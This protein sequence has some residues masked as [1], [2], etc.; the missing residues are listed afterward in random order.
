MKI[1]LRTKCFDIIP[2]TEKAMTEQLMDLNWFVIKLFTPMN[3]VCHSMQ[4]FFKNQINTL[5]NEFYYLPIPL[6]S[7]NLNTYLVIS[8]AEY[9]AKIV[10]WSKSSIIALSIVIMT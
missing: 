10:I 1:V 6:K 5:F 9:G 7:L 2:N 3:N 4:Y 8:T